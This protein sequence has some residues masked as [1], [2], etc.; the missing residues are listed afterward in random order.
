MIVW[1]LS[2]IIPKKFIY[3]ICNLIFFQKEDSLHLNLF[4]DCDNENKTKETED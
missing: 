3:K 1:C 2:A 4:S